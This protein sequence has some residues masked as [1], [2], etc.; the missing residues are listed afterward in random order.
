[1]RGFQISLIAALLSS[2]PLLTNFLQA[3]EL[4]PYK[5]NYLWGYKN[6]KGKI[7]VAPKYDTACTG[8]SNLYLVKNGGSF[9]VLGHQ[10]QELLP[11]SFEQVWFGEELRWGGAIVGLKNRRYTILDYKGT[12]LLQADLIEATA[13]GSKYMLV[14][15]GELWAIVSGNG[16]WLAKLS[17]DAIH[18]YDGGSYCIIERRHAKY[19]NAQGKFRFKIKPNKGYYAYALEFR[20]GYAP[21]EVEKK[22]WKRSWSALVHKYYSI[23][24][25]APYDRRRLKFM[26]IITRKYRNIIDTNGRYFIPDGFSIADGPYH[27]YA[28]AYSP[29]GKSG[30]GIVGRD[31]CFVVP[32]IYDNI[33]RVGDLYRLRKKDEVKVISLSETKLD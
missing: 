15:D 31:R 8:I 7:I 14:K 25:E 30:Y 12:F 32:P 26:E 5:Q 18:L 20:N 27:G 23:S 22:E 17:S 29:N 10:G 24:P 33:E 19:Y 4:L 3:Q 6:S 21:I 28:I 11:P 1:M 9:G 13:R 16:E 2:L